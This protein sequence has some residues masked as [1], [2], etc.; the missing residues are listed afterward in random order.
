MRIL[1]AAQMRDVERLT[2]L[3]GLTAAELME[4]AGSRVVEFLEERFAPLSGQSVV[5]FCG[6]GNNGGDGMV[7]ARQLFTRFRPQRLEVVT[8]GEPPEQLGLLRVCGLDA[9]ASPG[10]DAASATLVID[11]L[12][13]TGLKG[14]AKGPMLDAIR[15]INAGFPLARIVSVDIPSGLP[16]DSGAPLGES[17][18]ASHTVTFI[19]PKVGQVLPPN[20]DTVGELIVR[21]IGGEVDLPGNLMLS[22]PGYFRHLFAPRAPGAHK[23]DFGHVLVVGGARGK[24]GAAAMAGIAALR[25]GAGLVTVSSEERPGF[26]ELMTQPLG[27]SVAGMTRGRDVVA[28]GPGLG[29]APEMP[30]LAIRAYADCTLPMVVDA[31]ALNA[32]GATDLARPPALRV[33]TPHPGEM[34]RLTGRSVGEVQADRL[35][36]ARAYAVR[37]GVV[38]VLKGQRSIVAFPDGRAFVNPTG[39]PAMATAGTGDILTG[40]LAGMLGQFPRDQEAA[41]LAAVWLHGRAGEIGARQMGEKCL[42]ATDLLRFLP[43]AMASL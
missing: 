17:V 12:L 42:I 41:I 29:G 25:A 19:A 8:P 16:S 20:C 28:I 26:P 36:T 10:P 6:K 43:E 2:M 24:S 39:T 14:A 38:V 21:P 4:N 5:I 40:L 35:E 7:V 32:L 37:T 15:R 22:G 31:D 33:F 34:S 30:S 3:Q 27:H 13:G 9:V 18:R 23:G 1:T 11:A